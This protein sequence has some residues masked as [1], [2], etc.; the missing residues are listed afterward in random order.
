[1]IEAGAFSDIEKSRKQLLENFDYVM[2]T[3]KGKGT[4][5]QIDTQKLLEAAGDFKLQGTGEEFTNEEIQELEKEMFGFYLSKHPL[6]GLKEKNSHLITHDIIEVQ[7]LCDGSWVKLCG[8]ITQCKK[9]KSKKGNEFIAGEIEDLDATIRF[10]AFSSLIRKKEDYFKKGAKV[11]L[12]AK[13]QDKENN[14]VIVNDISFA[15][16]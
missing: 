9:L 12:H 10:V 7:D 11:I 6:E 1:M 8:V 14:S 15:N 3:I 5:E 2:E 16:E 13:L 4:R